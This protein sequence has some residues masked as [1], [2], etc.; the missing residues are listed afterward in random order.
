MVAGELG[1]LEEHSSKPATAPQ[2]RVNRYDGLVGHVLAALGPH[3]GWAVFLEGYSFGSRSGRG[4]VDRCEFGGVLRRALVH[5]ARV[6]SVVEVPPATLKRFAC[7]KGNA[8]KV[9]VATALTA[10]YGRTFG[11]DN[12]ADAFGLAMLGACVLGD[13]EPATKVQ[14]AVVDGL[15]GAGF[16][17]I[18][19]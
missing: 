1:I 19:S 16:P 17:Q 14:R 4:I 8:G 18:M 13:V 9:E 6:A 15:R 3:A 11:S 7:G 2:D 10:R 5:D 12:L